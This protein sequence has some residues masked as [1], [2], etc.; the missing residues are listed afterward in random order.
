MFN[1]ASPEDALLMTKEAFLLS[2]QLRL[3]VIVRMTTRVDHS[4]GVISYGKFDPKE[5]I[6]HF[7]RLPQHI[8]IP[9]RTATAHKTLLDKL[10]AE[11]FVSLNKKYNTVFSSG[12]V[13]KEQLGI[14]AS[15]VSLVYAQE[16]LSRNSDAKN[17]SVLKV[18][19]IHPFPEKD[20][21]AFLKKGIKKVLI[22]EELD[23]LLENDV[24]VSIQKNKID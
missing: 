17:I 3:P 20:I 2:A 8:N 7:D 22:L 1:P 16:L 13:G 11:I 15:G 24:R 9:A 18:A 19:V 21:L 10:D 4:R 12:K 23:P 5:T 6:A 14:I